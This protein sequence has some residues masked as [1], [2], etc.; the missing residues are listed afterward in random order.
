MRIGVLGNNGFLGKNLVTALL[1]SGHYIV[2]GSRSTNVDAM[3]YCNITDWINKNCLDSVIN[4][5]AECGGIGLNKK[6]P[7]KLWHRNN[8]INS[9]VLAASVNCEIKKL[10]M[11]GTVCSYSK[12]TPTPFKE[13]DLMRFGFPE[14]TNAAYGVSKLNALF[15]GVA[16][17]LQ[18]GLNVMNLI[19]VN[20]YGPH[21]HFDLEN[22]H[23]IPAIIRK[24]DDAIT[25][26][27]QE[28]VLWGDGS[29]SRE[30]LHVRDCSDAIIKALEYDK[31]CTDFINIGVGEETTIKN[32]TTMIVKIMKYDG[33]IIWDESKPNGQPRRCLNV[34]KINKLLNWRASISL[35]D[36]LVETIEWYKHNKGKI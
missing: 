17:N 12:N 21:D 23:V 28:I 18:T 4:C 16:A 5:A 6:F 7:F 26:N 15:G 25:N 14:E 3:N 9:N 19:P 8:I 32:L 2:G 31:I 10:I 22:S 13:E 20:M 33:K 30:F 34:D 36:G 29:A 11:L 1:K 24:V 27:S 35:Y